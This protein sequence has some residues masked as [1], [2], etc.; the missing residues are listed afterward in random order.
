MGW[1]IK[2]RDEGE[3]VG[4]IKL[5]IKGVVM[6]W[7]KKWIKKRMV[8]IIGEKG[9]EIVVGIVLIRLKEN[10]IIFFKKGFR[11][12]VIV[13]DWRVKIID[14]EEE[15]E[16][17]K[18]IDLKIIRVL[19]DVDWSRK[20]ERIRIKIDEEMLLKKEK[21][22]ELI[23]RVVW[24][25][26]GGEVIKLIKI[27]KI[28]GINEDRKEWG[29]EW[30]DDIVEVM[31]DMI[32]KIGI[33][34]EWVGVDLIEIKGLVR[35]VIIVEGD[36]IDIEEMIIE[37]LRKEFKEILVIEENDEEIDGIVL[38]MD[39]RGWKEEG[40]GRRGEEKGF[41]EREKGKRIEGKEWR[42]FLFNWCRII[43][44]R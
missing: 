25:E 14:G 24:K 22:K 43:W 41:K 26:K 13:E 20:N 31:I 18:L 44:G 10:G 1:L 19:K 21:R 38:W 15:E 7:G 28:E 33:V 12:K 2:G 40:E 9:D 3:I 27:I 8:E 29:I 42:N 6:E 39:G 16:G 5:G 37:L 30:K 35:M 32:V 11:R 17:V 36:E 34:M 23:G 4:E